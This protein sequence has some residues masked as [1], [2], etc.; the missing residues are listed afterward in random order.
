MRFANILAVNYITNTATTD[1]VTDTIR[2]ISTFGRYYS[3]ES[4][5]T[6]SE[7]TDTVSGNPVVQRPNQ[8]IQRPAT[9]AESIQ[10]ILTGNP[11]KRY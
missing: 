10:Y 11:V 3:V 4:T 2:H 6:A 1:N 5:N 9:T 8:L 7:S